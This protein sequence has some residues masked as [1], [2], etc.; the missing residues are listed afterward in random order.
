MME[1][2]NKMNSWKSEEFKSQFFNGDVQAEEI[3]KS[4]NF[5]TSSEFSFLNRIFQT[6]WCFFHKYIFFQSIL[7]RHRVFLCVPI[8]VI[9][10]KISTNFDSQ[11]SKITARIYAIENQNWNYRYMIMNNTAA[12]NSIRKQLEALFEERLKANK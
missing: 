5:I 12:E 6:F 1:N 8:L 2:E 10:N 4:L 7:S 9:N 3:I 11:I